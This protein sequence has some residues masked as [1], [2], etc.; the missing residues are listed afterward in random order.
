MAHRYGPERTCERCGAKYQGFASSQRYCSR[1]CHYATATGTE[2]RSGTRYIRKDGYVAVKVGVRAYRLE[3]QLVAESMLGRPLVSG[4]HVHHRNGDKQDNRP[5][6]LQVVTNAEHQ[7]M[8]EWSITKSGRVTLTCKRC[9]AEYE[10][11]ASRVAES[12]YCSAA[13]RLDV[14]HEAARA[15]WARRREEA[16]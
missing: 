8:H 14:Q 6:N 2:R 9:G 10:R 13:C 3:H 12:N 1:A 16:K 11:K 5:E 4:E 7:R 15:Y